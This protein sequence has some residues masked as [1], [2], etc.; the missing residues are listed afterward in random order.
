MDPKEKQKLMVLF[1][2]FGLAA[3]LM[4]YNLLLKPQV[5]GFSMRN[6]EY[7]AIKARV[8]SAEALIKNEARIRRQHEELK[9]QA[10][11]FENRLPVHDEISGLLEDFSGIAESSG[12]K[13]LRIKPLE[14]P[15][16]QSQAGK[17]YAAFMIL[18]EASAGYHQCGSFINKLEA[19]EKFIKVEDID[20][21]S[22]AADPR[23]HD[24]KLRTKTYIIR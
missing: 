13:I 22:V 18:I 23:R 7:K 3:M 16:G 9:K 4:F 12:V 8:K 1:G 2:I 15:S 19:M 11:I 10:G 17:A 21:K 20:I 5:S 14:S 6:R 24:I